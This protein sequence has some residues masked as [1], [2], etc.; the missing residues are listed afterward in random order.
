MKAEKLYDSAV[1][2]EPPRLPV[3][4]ASGK[5]P[6]SAPFKL[7][8]IGVPGIALLAW[9]YALWLSHSPAAL[10]SL[11][12]LMLFSVF[13]GAYAWFALKRAHSR[14]RRFNAWGGALLGFVGLW[15]HWAL[16]IRMGFDEG[17]T[18]AGYFITADPVGWVSMLGLLAGRLAQLEPTRFLVHWLPL[19]WLAEAAILVWL[20]VVI[21]RTLT[22]EPYSE[23]LGA[24]AS[25]DVTGELWW[26]GG[27]SSELRSRLEEEGVAFLLTM[28]RAVEVGLSQEARWWTASVI[29]Q[30]VAADPAA[31][32]LTVSIAEYSRAADGKI[33]T[34]RFPVVA[35]WVVDAADYDRLASHLS[36]APLATTVASGGTPAELLPAVAAMESDDFGRAVEL[37]EDLRNH[38]D[39][40][41]RADALRLCAL[42]LAR[43]EKWNRAFD[44][45]HALFA[46]EPSVMNALQLATTSVMA[47]ELARGQAWFEKACQL[48]S[49]EQTMPWPDLQTNFLSAL[50]QKGEW[51]AGLPHVEWLRDMFQGMTSSDDHFVHMHGMPFLSV[52]FEKS[53]P[54][55]RASLGQTELLAW[56][57]AMQ[58]HLDA[59]GQEKLTAWLETLRAA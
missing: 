41:L 37:A 19:L 44:D 7:L 31:R 50:A 27:L 45:Y 47:G 13:F 51:A 20:P 52:F 48:N 22:G 32:W 12:G 28:A 4:V 2:P 55:L 1:V 42:C 9:L 46:C 39:A 34:E 3:Y 30:K 18:L 29:C 15:V 17:P 24:W 33:K 54:F 6:W 10:I 53:L 16:W 36:T 8:L 56:Y 40:A 38:S 59:E 5:F 58:A 57:G 21:A 43:L 35:E 25:A 11:F 26:E 14:S 23:A 49:E